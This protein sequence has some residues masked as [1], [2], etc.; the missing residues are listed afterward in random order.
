ML[1]SLLSVSR[2]KLFQVMHIEERP[3][4]AVV[5]VLEPPQSVKVKGFGQIHC[6]P[7]GGY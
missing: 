5:P 6:P 7:L 1:M 2:M 4:A 3:S